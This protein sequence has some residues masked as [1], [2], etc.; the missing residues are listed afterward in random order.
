VRNGGRRTM[1]TPPD[2]PA[3]RDPMY[4]L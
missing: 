3:K 4:N 2:E 1:P